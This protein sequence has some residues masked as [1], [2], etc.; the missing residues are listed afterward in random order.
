MPST[1]MLAAHQGQNRSFGEPFRSDSSMTLMP[2]S[3]TASAEPVRVV[4]VDIASPIGPPARDR[5][6][7]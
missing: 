5:A 2:F 6:G 4:S 3:S 7:R 1:E